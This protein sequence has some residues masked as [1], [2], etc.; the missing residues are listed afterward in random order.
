MLGVCRELQQ[1]SAARRYKDT[2]AQRRSRFPS[3]LALSVS[4][5]AG[6]AVPQGGAGEAV[7]QGGAC[8]AWPESL[9]ASF[10]S[11]LPACG[12]F[13]ALLY[14]SLGISDSVQRETRSS[15]THAFVA[16][17]LGI[18]VLALGRLQARRRAA[19]RIAAPPAFSLTINTQVVPWA[20]CPTED[21]NQGRF[22]AAI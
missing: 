21:S 22:S 10:Q 3:C 11:A 13:L 1:Q 8:R 7:L 14:P 2:K 12:S 4:C 15:H 19:H 16:S 18:L 20:A 5:S 17:C 9:T 6:K